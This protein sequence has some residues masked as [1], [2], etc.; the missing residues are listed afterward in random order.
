[1]IINC[2]YVAKEMIL[3]GIDDL[4]FGKVEKW[5]A[6]R[7]KRNGSKTFW[8]AK[9]RIF[10]PWIGHGWHIFTNCKDFCS[11]AGDVHHLNGSI[12]GPAVIFLTPN[13]AAINFIFVGEVCS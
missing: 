13:V 7:A 4:L 12:G 1:M 3:E 8:W 5:R 11:L 6:E 9:L 2:S 10:H